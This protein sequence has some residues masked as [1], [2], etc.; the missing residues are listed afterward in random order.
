[1]KQRGLHLQLGVWDCLRA[2]GGVGLGWV[3][4]DWVGVSI[5][6][7][8]WFS[9]HIKLNPMHLL[10]HTCT[11]THTH[12]CTHTYSFRHPRMDIQGASCLENTKFSF[13]VHQFI[14]IITTI[15]RRLVVIVYKWSLKPWHPT[16]LTVHPVNMCSVVSSP[17]QSLPAHLELCGL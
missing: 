3:G 7:N 6:G 14:I 12:A 15:F 17:S 11:H 1:M 5:C 2:G 4:G 13:K 10:W 16:C 9:L 8:L